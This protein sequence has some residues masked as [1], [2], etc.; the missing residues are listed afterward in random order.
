M[1]VLPNCVI[2]TIGTLMDNISTNTPF[3]QYQIH[4]IDLR[5]YGLKS[6]HIAYVITQECRSVTDGPPKT[7]RHLFSLSI[8]WNS[9]YPI[10]DYPNT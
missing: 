4:P 1:I 9:D 2:S 8:Q 6:L 10:I 7:R 3:G 5:M